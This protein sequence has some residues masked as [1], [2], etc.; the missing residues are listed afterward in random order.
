ML[1]FKKNK[2]KKFKGRGKIRDQLLNTRSLV[3]YQEIH[4]NYCHQMSQMHQILFPASVS[5]RPSV[6]LLDAEVD[7]KA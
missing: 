2:F 6:R 5:V 4:K 7:T 3:N 1:Q